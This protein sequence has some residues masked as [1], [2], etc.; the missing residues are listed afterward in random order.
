MLAKGAERAWV[1]GVFPDDTRF[2]EDLML[3]PRLDAHTERGQPGAQQIHQLAE[4][5]VLNPRGPFPRTFP[6][7]QLAAASG[8]TELP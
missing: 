8:S 3:V 2:Q 5:L 6:T 7:P 1:S 4:M